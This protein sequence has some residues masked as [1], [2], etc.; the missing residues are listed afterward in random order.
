VHLD[1]LSFPATALRK[2]FFD[3]AEAELAS[4]A[5][6]CLEIEM[7]PLIS[8][9]GFPR[10]RLL[11]RLRREVEIAERLKVPIVISSGATN[12]YLLRGPHDYA[13]LA[14]LFD[15][16]LP[17]ALRALSEDPVSMVERNREKL[18]PYYV[19]PG[20]RVVGRKKSV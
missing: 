19:A 8:L 15:M 18:S 17:S 6:S 5:L 16:P 13:S 20:I 9:T 11:S 3:H 12:E 14:T 7:A 2:R 4:K 10:I 1:L